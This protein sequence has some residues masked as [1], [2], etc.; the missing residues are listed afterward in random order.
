MPECDSPD[1]AIEYLGVSVRDIFEEQLDGWY[2]V[3]GVCLQSEIC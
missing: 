2:R 1:Q 3:P